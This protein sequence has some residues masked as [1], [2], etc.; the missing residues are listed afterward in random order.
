LD[1][2]AAKN[3]GGC[4]TALPSRDG[5]SGSSWP[6]LELSLAFF[7]VALLALGGLV[8]GAGRNP[9]WIVLI[10]ALFPMISVVLQSVVERLLPPAGPRKSLRSWLPHFQVNTFFN[11]MLAAL[12]VAA[13]LGCSALARSFGFELGL[14]DIRFTFGKGLLVLVASLWL[15]SIFG[16][17]FFYWYHRWTHENEFLWQ[18]HKMHHTDRE[19]E[20]I[21]TARQNWME[22]VFNSLFISVPMIVL[23][24]VHPQDQW[25]TGILAGLTAS[26]LTN[27]LTLSHMNVRW[28]VGWLSRFWCSPQIH[29]LHHSLSPEHINK[30][31]A[32][33]FPMWD[34]LFGT[35]CHPKKDE[36]PA[37]GVAGERGFSSFW[38]AEI[39]SQREWLKFIRNRRSRT[40]GAN[41]RTQSL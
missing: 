27:F 5:V 39:Y 28:Q 13:F 34:V 1:F 37:T 35:Y 30:N 10:S 19:L 16:D 9:L 3:S 18:H 41:A 14:F 17:F 11:F 21:S 22:A 26:F 24:K 2:D 4:V 15:S 36:F 32:F 31:Y 8:L 20:A 40:A 38:E 29:R 33:V 6:F 7:L 23:F 25:S 12:S